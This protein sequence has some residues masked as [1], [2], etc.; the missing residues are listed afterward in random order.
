LSVLNKLE[1]NLRKGYDIIIVLDVN[2]FDSRTNGLHAVTYLG[3][4]KVNGNNVS[5]KVQSW[6]KEMTINTTLSNFKKN[7]E[8]AINGKKSN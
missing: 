2:M 1:S 5:F 3:E 7:F 4:L 6:G 8:S